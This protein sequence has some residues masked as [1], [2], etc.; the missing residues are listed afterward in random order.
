MEGQ[1]TILEIGHT[2]VGRKA[3]LMQIH[4]REI[5]EVKVEKLPLNIKKDINKALD[6]KLS[7]YDIRGNMYGDDIN[8]EG[9]E[10]IWVPQA[11]K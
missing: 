10:T 6:G 4:S 7:F 9:I 11:V 5:I 3:L 1:F 8:D 2:V